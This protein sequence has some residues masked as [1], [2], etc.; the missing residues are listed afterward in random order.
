MPLNFDDLIPQ[1]GAGRG[2]LLSNA[3]LPSGFVLDPQQPGAPNIFDQFDPKPTGNYFDRFDP[4]ARGRLN[5]DDLIPQNQGAALPPGYVLDQ[6]QGSNYFDQFDPK[7]L[8]AADMAKGGGVGVLKGVIGLAGLPGD[9]SKFATPDAQQQPVPDGLY[10]KVIN[11]LNTARGALELPT[12]S[13]I[14]SGVEGA[15]GPLYDAKTRA[16]KLMETGGEFLPAVLGGPESL[17]SRLIG[18]VIAPATASEGLG[19][20]TEGTAAEPFARIGGALLG[21]GAAGG[22]SR[23]LRS[24]P[25][26]PSAEELQSAING[27]GR[28]YNDPA[29]QDLRL[30]PEAMGRLADKINDN[31]LQNKIDP[32][33]APNVSRTVNQL[34]NG[35]RFEE[36]TSQTNTVLSGP[37]FHIADDITQPA[38]YQIADIDLARQ[39]LG[40]APFEE[41]RAAAIARSA[42]DNYLGNIPQSDV[43]SGNAAAANQALSDARGNF[44]A[45][46]RAQDV[47]N[48][49]G[50]AENQ[51]GSTYSGHNLDN[52]TRQQLRPILNQKEGVSKTPAF[53][54]YTDDEIAALRG[55]VNGSFLRNTIRD[56]G[57]QLGG[58][59]GLGNITAGL[60]TG[61]TAHE[62]GA[63]PMTSIGLGLGAMVGGRALGGL[64]NRMTAAEAEQMA[65]LLRSRS[66]LGAQ[67][68]A[69][70][71][72]VLPPPNIRRNLMRGAVMALPSA[73]GQ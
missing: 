56:V 73:Q 20:L 69:N 21:A 24:G 64:A 27:A 51:A 10:G 57:K 41:R 15:V 4:P 66:P 59:G 34:G 22:L 53:Q 40:D 44:S 9:A 61:V 65:A 25:V 33:N 5:F 29:V 13:G 8:D 30:A 32:L 17:A 58:G 14:R 36:P 60:G 26:S 70:A 54:D 12:S 49:L 31:L 28:G 11:A 50:R 48:A 52:A 6:P 7:G 42:I 63:D 39:S 38:P 37:G 47:S 2:K 18:R 23:A 46:K 68:R 67:M 72:A 3:Q 71:P 16:G 45:M 19:E 1:T 35:A 43:V 62:A 55:S